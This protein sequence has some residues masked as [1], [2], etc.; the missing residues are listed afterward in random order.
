MKKWITLPFL[1][2]LTLM[3]CNKSPE[4]ETTTPTTVA[5]S[6]ET[7]YLQ[8]FLSTNNIT[9]TQKNGMF[10]TLTQVN[11]TSPNACGRLAVKYKGQIIN[12][13]S[14]GGTFDETVGSAVATFNLN[15]VIVGWQIIFPLAKLSKVYIIFL[16]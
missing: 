6:T 2:L 12:A 9:A 15:Q 3:A 11:G 7:V 14:L 13:T 5:T 8:N 10:Y 1:T 4:C 16:F